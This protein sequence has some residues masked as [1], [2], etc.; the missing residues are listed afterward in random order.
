MNK[1]GGGSVGSVGGGAGFGVGNAPAAGPTAAATAAAQQRQR[2]LLQRAD[3]DIGSLLDNFSHLVKAARINDPLRNS[4]ESF[5]MEV[6]ASRVV[7]AADSLLKLVSELK[8]TA[9]FSDFTALNEQIEKRSATFVHLNEETEQLLMSVGE[10]VAA[11]LQDLESHYYNSSHRTVNLENG[12][13]KSNG[14][15]PELF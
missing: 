12:D 2:T 1:P 9:V 14:D 8:Q 13:H 15:L 4:Q 3:I 5:Q 7:Q 6:H 11:S 10:E